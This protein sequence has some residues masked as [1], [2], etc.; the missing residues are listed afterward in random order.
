[1]MNKK[2]TLVFG[3]ILVIAILTVIGFASHGEGSI[4][5]TPR[6]GATF[7]PVLASWFLLAPWFGLFDKSTVAS[8]KFLWRVPLA[9]LFVAPLASIL[10]AALLGSAAVPLFTLILAFTTALGM[11]T[12]RVVYLVLSKK[13]A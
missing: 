5:F 9:M 8:F 2:S 12:W 6:M 11:F 7:F 4:S 1:M 10:R 13:Q 3:D